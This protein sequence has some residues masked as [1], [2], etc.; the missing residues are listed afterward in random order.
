MQEIAGLGRVYLGWAVDWKIQAGT[1]YRTWAVSDKGNSSSTMVVIKNCPTRWLFKFKMSR[2]SNCTYQGPLTC[3]RLELHQIFMQNWIAQ[4]VQS[5]GIA[6]CLVA[7]LKLEITH[8]WSTWKTSW[9]KTVW[10][11]SKFFRRHDLTPPCDWII[12]SVYSAKFL[13][14]SPILWYL[15]M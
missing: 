9:A 5:K 15:R 2:S 10:A 6:F 3:S 8:R 12:S 13:R 7:F 14:K 11:T 1:V 4:R